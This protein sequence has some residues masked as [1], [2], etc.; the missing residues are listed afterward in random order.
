MAIRNSHQSE[1]QYMFME[2]NIH[3]AHIKIVKAN[4]GHDQLGK[5]TSTNSPLDPLTFL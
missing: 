2:I 5:Q 4:F 3:T 1:D